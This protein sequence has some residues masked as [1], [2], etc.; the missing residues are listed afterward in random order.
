[1]ID[2][3]VLGPVRAL[4]GRHDLDIGHARQRSLLAILLVDVNNVVPTERLTALM[5]DDRP[6]RGARN[7]LAGYAARLRKVLAAAPGR[8]VLVSEANGY[9]LR[10]DPTAVDLCRFR[11]LTARAAGAEDDEERSQLLA[12]A[13]AQ[14]S[15]AALGDL[16]G[17]HVD[18]LRTTLEGER[19]TAL[20]EYYDTRLLLGRPQEI[21]P[22]L[23]QMTEERP[24][25]EELALRLIRAH[26]DSGNP[27]AALRTYEA[28]RSRLAREL[29]T[30]PGEA[31]RRAGEQ[32]LRPA[33]H[34]AGDA[35]AAPVASQA[36]ERLRMPVS[37][38]YFAG[39]VRELDALDELLTPRR[40]A[41]GSQGTNLAVISG[42]A[43]AGKTT[44]ALRW[45]QRAGTAFPDGQLFVP[46]RG[47]ERHLPPLEP[48]EILVSVL[49]A[50]GLP[51]ADIP[52]GL[53]ERAALYRTLLVG[54]RV[55]LV[56]DDAASPEQVRHLLPP[57]VDGSAV[58]VTSR[59]RLPGLT[60][61]YFAGEVLLD[62]LDDASAL[63]LLASLVGS[64]RVAREP[65]AASGI[66]EASGRLPLT[67]RLS[68]A[69]AASHPDEPLGLLLAQVPTT[70]GADAHGAMG[71][72]LDLSYGKLTEVQRR[73][74]RQ[75]GVVP[76]TEFGRETVGA[77]ADCPFAVLEEAIGAL[78]RANLLAE[79][80]PRR[81]RMHDMVKEYSVGRATEEDPWEAR[82]DVLLRLLEWYREA[83]ERASLAD[84]IQ[85]SG[86]HRGA[87]VAALLPWGGRPRT[88]PGT[89]TGSGTARGT[90]GPAGAAGAVG[91]RAEDAA[92]SRGT[93]IDV[94]WLD[95]EKT[96]LCAAIRLASELGLGPASWR[97]ADAMLGYIR[98]HPGGDDWSSAVEA[99]QR[100]AARSGHERANTA[101]LLNVADS[102]YREGHYRA[103]RQR[104]REALTVS[105]GAS[106]RAGE[107]LSLAVLS[108]TY[109]SVGVLGLA[110]RYMR[111]AQ[112]IHEEL[113]DLAGQANAVAR[114]ARNA[115]DAGDPGAALH[116]FRDALR[117]AEQSGSRFG[118]IR[119]PA[120]VAL[121]LRQLGE[122]AE[123]QQW[124]ELA[125]LTSRE[126]DFHEGVAIALSC[127][128]ELFGDVG[129]H[130]EA[131]TSAREAHVAIP[132]LSDPRI[133]ADCLIRLGSVEA[134][135]D[136]AELAM[137]SFGRALVM[138]EQVNYPQAAA[139]AQAES[140]AAYV[141]L[142]LY[143][144][145]LA[146]CRRARRVL[147]GCDMR[148]VRAQ[149]LMAEA[150]CALASGRCAAA[151]AG[152]RQASALYRAAGHRLGEIRALLS[153][154]RA[155][156]T[157]PHH[158]HPARLW[159]HA[160]RLADPLAVPEA[161]TLRTLLHNTRA[162]TT[163]T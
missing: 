28:V 38:G 155:A 56:L 144:E 71:R 7:A 138:A 105:R 27:A 29:S 163:H 145:A 152:Y 90:D 162:G 122:H 126:M 118:Q 11:D 160:L 60:A 48:S 111:A 26:R 49:L 67:V 102:R 157:A 141:R 156:A 95:R 74:F 35:P 63:E 5:W 2:L 85:M 61:T 70:D 33:P 146:A 97:L 96:N 130:A 69:Y 59:E 15:G 101:M 66:V 30:R 131:V 44:L 129:A 151:V 65:A 103:E 128:A 6:P 54:R 148:L 75:L 10:V 93:G 4:A 108:R 99:A 143:E 120:Y 31:L 83:V 3:R 117:L 115:Y 150:D 92:G 43:G 50:L 104:A 62:A 89:G 116:G 100:A 40:E 19:Q 25:D 135:A 64:A 88:V 124:C 91:D 72:A 112:R 140:A 47:H 142:G 79:Y 106:W 123:A 159:R 18:S 110:D 81:Y 132:H 42:M 121:S 39:R 9:V 24:Y 109:W 136:H 32:L 147:R 58:L 41:G 55:L 78:V 127:R 139:R 158:G 53:D 73:V 153:W 45:A 52:F 1:M 23:Q 149:T 114:L 36:R 161:D 113:G 17:G 119:L 37:S 137:R 80:G 51:A 14:W 134:A 22:P 12:A 20:L 68:G 77:L 94:A 86:V 98:L 16:D 57:S 133:E 107:A 8:P 46:L 82:R 87:A 76:G 21:V 34:P 125:I 154:G 84:G 13:L